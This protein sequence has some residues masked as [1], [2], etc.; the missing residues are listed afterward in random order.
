M[1]TNPHSH[2]IPQL[3]AR[4]K[5]TASWA[6]L[7]SF[8]A[9]WGAL[10]VLRN[11]DQSAALLNKFTRYG[12]AVPNYRFF[13]PNPGT[14]DLSLIIRHRNRDGSLTEWNQVVVGEERK[15][16]H[17]LWAPFRR[18]E[19]VITDAV[20]DIYRTGN[21]VLSKDFLPETVG[22]KLLLNVARN[23]A[24]HDSTATDVQFA[25]CQLAAYEPLLGPQ[26]TY[27]SPFH[28]L[29]TAEITAEHIPQ[30]TAAMVKAS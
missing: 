27:V 15:L 18:P 5:R 6:A 12:L 29:T 25:I 10:T 20:R 23:Q 9:M 1:T 11:L 30:P 21:N 19:K 24:P 14:H 8:F 22:Y 7:Y 3:P 13:G 16:I 2:R 28:D 26:I 17:T 4:G